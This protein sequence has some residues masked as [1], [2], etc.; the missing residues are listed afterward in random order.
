[1]CISII[2]FVWGGGA[3]CYPSIHSFIAQMGWGIVFFVLFL[4]EEPVSSIYY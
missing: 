1:M 4:G 3:F 2:Q